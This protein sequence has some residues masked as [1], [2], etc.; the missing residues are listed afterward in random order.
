MIN[1]LLGGGLIDEAT[2]L[3]RQMEENGCPPNNDC[4]L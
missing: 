1:G 4:T 2:V 3:F